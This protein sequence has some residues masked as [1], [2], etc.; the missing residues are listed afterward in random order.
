MHFRQKKPTDDHI[1][2]NYSLMFNK[3]Y[4]CLFTRN[5]HASVFTNLLKIIFK[6]VVV[7]A[8]PS[9]IIAYTGLNDNNHELHNIKLTFRVERSK[10][11]G[12]SPC[13]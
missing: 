4:I 11:F 8:H 6:Y 5:I 10:M 9:N 12:L 2:G 3:I 7:H 1:T 13:R